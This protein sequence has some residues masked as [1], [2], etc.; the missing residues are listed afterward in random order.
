[1]TFKLALIAGVAALSLPAL[2]P[3]SAQTVD[4]YGNLGYTQFDGNAVDLGGVTARVGAG[5]GKYFAVEGEGTVGTHKDGGV[6]L[7]SELGIFAVGKLPV[8]ERFDLFAR[9][10]AS[11]VETSPGGDDEA[12][13]YGAGAQYFFTDKDGIRGD[14]TKHDFD[15]GGDV[16]TYSVSYV[17]KF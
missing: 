11:R 7:D 2:A 9:V 3:A 1:M 14:W 17:R 16:D 13:A 8:T 10:G 15:N 12:F 5:F 4:L 6:K